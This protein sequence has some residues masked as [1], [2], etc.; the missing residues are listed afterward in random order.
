MGAHKRNS[1]RKTNLELVKLVENLYTISAKEKSPV[2]RDVAMRLEKPIGNR[3]VIN[4]ARLDRYTKEGD[5]IV[6]PG[7]ILGM[8]RMSKKITV[9][10]YMLSSSAVAKLEKAGCKLYDLQSLARDNP[11]GS[12][13]KLMA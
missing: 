2:W 4:L 11:K 1:G 13:I 7:K 6:V 10:A 8:G 9:S 3:A 5:V 12:G